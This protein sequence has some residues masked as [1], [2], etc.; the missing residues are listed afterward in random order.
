MATKRVIENSKKLSI[1][2]ELSRMSPIFMKKERW[3]LAKTLE[4]SK[5]MPER[6]VVKRRGVVWSFRCR[7]RYNGDTG[8]NQN[9]I[10]E[11]LNGRT[12]MNC[13]YGRGGEGNRGGNEDAGSWMGK[14]NPKVSL[15]AT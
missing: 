13:D 5:T 12:E 6:C 7:Y 4:G 11:M 3:T 1:K 9:N 14:C 15:R 8:R 2:P 10:M